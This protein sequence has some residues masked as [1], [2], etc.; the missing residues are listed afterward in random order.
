MSIYATKSWIGGVSLYLCSSS[1]W[2][3]KSLEPMFSRPKYEDIP[4]AQYKMAWPKNF[5]F[6]LIMKVDANVSCL[7]ML[8]MNG[9]EGMSWW[10]QWVVSHD[11][12]TSS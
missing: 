10:W 12:S 5:Q 11:E 7:P 4:M 2:Q 9:K 3:N 6:V 1:Y 8:L